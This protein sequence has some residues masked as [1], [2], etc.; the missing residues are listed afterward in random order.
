[1]EAAIYALLAS[2]AGGRRYWLR[3]PQDVTAAPYLILQRISSTPFHLYAGPDGLQD[4]RI[5]IDIYAGTYTEARD[6]ANAVIAFLSGYR[7]GAIQ[8]AFLDGRRDLPAA[9]AGEVNSL[10][11]TSLDFII[12]HKE[13]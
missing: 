11:R 6:T 2:V 13:T 3:K 5:Q 10:F 12:R 8:G 4:D 1:M 9:D 7:G